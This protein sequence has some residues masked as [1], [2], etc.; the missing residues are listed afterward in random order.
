MALGLFFYARR[1]FG[2][3]F[4]HQELHVLRHQFLDVTIALDGRV[5]VGHL[6]GGHVA[7]NIAAS[8]IALVIIVRPLRALAKHTDGTPI[9]MLD[10]G[11][12]VEERLRGG[13][14]I[15]GRKYMCM[16]YIKAT[17]KGAGN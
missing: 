4:F 2:A 15:H 3:G 13:F 10:L 1:S 5:E 14:G 7:G 16:P 17:K 12:G 8:L 6:F 11:D 9:Q